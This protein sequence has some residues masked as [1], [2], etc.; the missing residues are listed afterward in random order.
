MKLEDRIKKAIEILFFRLVGYKKYRSQKAQDKW[1]IEDV[2]N[3]KKGGYF[4]DLA[5]ANGK[6]LSNTYLLEILLG[7]DGI[8]IEPN[9]RFNKMLKNFR[10]V[11]IAKV[12]IDEKPGEV[13][14]YE[15]NE[16]GGIVADD[17][18]NNP[19]VR[20]ELKGK[21]FKTVKAVTLES[22]LDEYKAPLV[23]DYLSLD[24]EGAEE[25]I[26]RNFNFD[27]YTFLAMTIERPSV[28]LNRILMDND[29]C[30]VRNQNYDTFY[31]HKS[32]VNFDSIQKEEF[33]QVP[34]K[35]R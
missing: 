2:F 35:E 15:N 28:E 26:L 21:S 24:V 30:F 18:D 1:I 20:K 14:F 32:I 34:K 12:C 9:D 22:L 25:R 7:W 3:H 23:I 5:A 6:Y 11:N 31:V 10:N 8:C 17:T 4:I 29:Y 27:K 16:L 33:S 19:E 13:V